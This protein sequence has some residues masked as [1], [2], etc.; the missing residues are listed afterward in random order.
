MMG[1]WK[2]QRERYDRMSPGAKL[3]V[4]VSVGGLPLYFLVKFIWNWL[5]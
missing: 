1:Y 5:T 4:L 2:T 3:Y